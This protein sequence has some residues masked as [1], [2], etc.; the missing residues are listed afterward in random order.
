M[1]ITFA[2]EPPT[3][4]QWGTAASPAGPLVVGVDGKGRICRIAFQRDRDAKDILA[5]WQMEW[6]HTVFT[7]GGKIGDLSD[8]PVCVIGTAFQHSVWRV[9][10]K[11]PRGSV[12]TYGGIAA[13]IGKHKAARAVGTACGANLVPYVIPC[14]R[15][16]AGNGKLGGFSSG[17]DVKKKLLQA[18]G[19]L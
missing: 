1:K 14:H 4:V 13:A 3:A 12:T 19:W 18:E 8:Y 6:P 5:E 16:I 2:D 11:I 10:A 17:L 15:V 7:R 9:M